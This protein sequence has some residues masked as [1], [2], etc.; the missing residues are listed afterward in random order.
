MLKILS[1][2]KIRAILH[3][4]YRK[5]SNRVRS[6]DLA[7]QLIVRL[8]IQLLS[9]F[10]DSCSLTVLKEYAGAPCFLKNGKTGIFCTY[11]SPQYQRV[12]LYDA[13]PRK[14]RSPITKVKCIELYTII[15]SLL[16]CTCSI[17]CCL[18]LS[19]LGTAIVHDSVRAKKPS[20]RRR[21]S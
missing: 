7:G 17:A 12:D 16:V 4:I 3:I 20:F 11:C 1:S 21:N 9:I 5:K 6:G 19:D 13:L 18:T 8:F 15:F 14:K 2:F 10:I